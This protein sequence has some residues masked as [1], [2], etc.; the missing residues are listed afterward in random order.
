MTAPAPAAQPAAM[1]ETAQLPPKAKALMEIGWDNMGA[2]ERLELFART[3]P[4]Y[5]KKELFG[6]IQK[7]GSFAAR[8]AGPALGQKIG[9]FTRIPL[10]DRILGGVGGAVGEIVGENIDD[11]PFSPGKIMGAAFGGFTKGKPLGGA[12]AREVG[13]EALKDAGVNVAAKTLETGVSEGR[14]PTAGEATLAAAGGVGGTIAGKALDKGGATALAT[15]GRTAPADAVVAQARKRGYVFLPSK[16]GSSGTGDITDFLGGASPNSSALANVAV[17]RNQEVTDDLA[18]AYIK[19]PKD[20]PLDETNLATL[21]H[22]AE[23]PYR[24][25]AALSPQA[26]GSLEMFRQAKSD[27]KKAWRAYDRTPSPELKKFADENDQLADLAMDDMIAEA[28]TAGRPQLIPE[29]EKG[30]VELAKLH[31]VDRAMNYGDYHASAKTFSNAFEL[32]NTAK[33]G[34]LL[35][36][37]AELIAR[38]HL[39]FPGIMRDASSVT[40]TGSGKLPLVGAAVRAVTLSEPGQALIMRG[41]GGPSPAQDATAAAGRQGAM[42]EG[43][44]DKFTVGRIY[45]NPKGQRAEYLGGGKWKEQ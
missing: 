31:L 44:D 7:G 19:A 41:R 9:Q 16:M 32:A 13:A 30:R 2:V 36:D 38:M 10:M 1:D 27:A 14:L 4:E 21:F 25:V 45:R 34:S 23:E 24:K 3:A 11:E 28:R 18:R 15:A 39:A 29:L 26:A 22:A 43:R 8:A 17:L 6:D 5:A 33:R 35:T 20:M 42:S 12:T 40:T 37:E